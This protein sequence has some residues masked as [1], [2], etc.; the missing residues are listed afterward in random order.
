[1]PVLL[2]PSPA[3]GPFEPYPPVKQNSQ[4]FVC[5]YNSAC[6]L[7]VHKSWISLPLPSPLSPC[8][9]NS[10]S[11]PKMKHPD[12]FLPSPCKLD[13]SSSFSDGLTDSFLLSLLQLW[14]KGGSCNIFMHTKCDSP[15][16]S[17]SDGSIQTSSLVWILLFYALQSL[18]ISST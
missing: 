16:K 14:N 8:F 4:T 13:H 3:S 9:L 5:L 18:L 12:L 17:H 10:H 6:L 7:S 11:S 1:M 2:A 15:H